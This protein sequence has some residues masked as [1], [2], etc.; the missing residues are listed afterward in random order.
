MPASWLLRVFRNSGIGLHTFA[1]G[2]I[3]RLLPLLRSG[4]FGLFNCD[5]RWL[6]NC[7]PH[8]SERGIPN[9]AGHPREVRADVTCTTATGQ[10]ADSAG[11]RPEPA[12][13]V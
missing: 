9:L 13:S 12:T 10:T 4:R 11:A 5:N 2:L 1:I 8:R 6:L 7:E 3:G